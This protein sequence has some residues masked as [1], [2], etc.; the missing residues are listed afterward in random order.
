[1]STE[2]FATSTCVTSARRARSQRPAPSSPLRFMRAGKCSEPITTGTP[3]IS[4]YADA[5]ILSDNGGDFK[6]AVPKTVVKG[7]TWVA[8]QANLDFAQGGEWGWEN[9]TTV[10]GSAAAWENPG[11]GFGT[12]CTTWKTETSCI[13]D[14]QGDHMFTLLG[15]GH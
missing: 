8:V 2:A 5:T 1:M 6:V 12:G 14:G 3:T 9:Q 4:S 10:V 11:D 7:T 15:K 13:A